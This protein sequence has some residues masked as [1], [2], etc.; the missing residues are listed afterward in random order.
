VSEK[1]WESQAFLLVNPWALLWE[2]SS[3]Q[4]WVPMSELLWETLWA[5]P[6]AHV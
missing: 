2:P 3:G 6:L 1:L 4:T 5:C